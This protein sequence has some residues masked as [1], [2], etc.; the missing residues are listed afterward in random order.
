MGIGIV[1]LAL[2]G[3]DIFFYLV[4]ELRYIGKGQYSL[5]TVFMF[6]GL[7]IPT[8][9]YFLYP[10]SALL[11]TLLVLGQLA[12]SSELV[13]LQSSGL[14]ITRQAILV[15][16]ATLVITMIMFIVGEVIAPLTEQVAQKKKMTAISSGKA[17]QIQ[18][19]VWVRNQDSFI[20]IKHSNGED[21]LQQL[22]IYNFDDELNLQIAMHAN[23]ALKKDTG[24]QLQN[25]SGTRF[26]RDR[27]ESFRKPKMFVKQLVDID[28]L[29]ATSIKHL[30]RLSFRQ[31]VKIIKL[32]VGNN[33]DVQDYIFAFWL[34]VFH[35]IGALVMIFLAVP[36]A[37]GPLRSSSSGL[38]LLTGVLIG[39]TF[40]ITNTVIAPMVTV[41]EMSPFLAA[42]TPSILF[43]GIGCWL[44]RTTST[45]R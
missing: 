24:W 43:I 8:K 40:Y 33:L 10:W 37:F 31:L 9:L 39:F 17:M 11:G 30:E 19:G 21:D 1:L 4:N 42:A 29:Q 15:F 2:L 22:T 20:Y 36:F 13:V 27:I 16:K 32:R 5:L 35:P 3:I 7:K 28:V 45:V 12:R 6:V 14:S 26:Y 18:G 25:I 34:K 41:V 38:R 23:R 44:V